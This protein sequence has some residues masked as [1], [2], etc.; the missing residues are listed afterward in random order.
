MINVWNAYNALITYAWSRSAS[1]IYNGERD[2]L[3]FRDTVQDMLGNLTRYGNSFGK[4][5]RMRARWVQSSGL[6]IKDA[7]KEPVEYLWFVGDYASYDPRCEEITRKTA[8][9]FAKACGNDEAWSCGDL[10]FMYASALIDG[11]EDRPKAA[12][13]YRKACEGGYAVACG[14]LGAAHQ[15]GN[16]VP[17]DAAKA[18][19]LYRKGCEGGAAGA[20]LGL[21]ELYR[22]GAGG[23]AKDVAK[24]KELTKRAC[25]LGSDRACKAMKAKWYE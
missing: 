9:I 22:D 18:A 17:K 11:K 2:G 12:E 1:L 8:Q 21:G 5:D 10:G 24:G 23:L 15:D 6:K 3:G 20:C 16:G 13:L 25:D 19:E 7:R 4:S 14:N